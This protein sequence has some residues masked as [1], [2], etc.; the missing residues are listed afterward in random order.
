MQLIFV[1]VWESEFKR[2]YSVYLGSGYLRYKNICNSLNSL[3]ADRLCKGYR[4][5]FVSGNDFEFP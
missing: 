4:S 1:Y 5:V 2:R 3:H